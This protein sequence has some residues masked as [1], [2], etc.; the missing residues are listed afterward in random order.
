MK[1]GVARE[2]PNLRHITNH[3]ILIVIDYASML[4]IPTN[5]SMHI[6]YIP[7][8]NHNSKGK[9]LNHG[10]SSAV[11]INETRLYLVV[12]IRI[13]LV[14]IKPYYMEFS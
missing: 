2:N 8:V 3:D 4:H 1:K 14:T 10:L 9:P 13:P 12:L 11:N 6:C 7:K 5:N